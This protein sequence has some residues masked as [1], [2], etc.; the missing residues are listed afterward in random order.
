MPRT[1]E[2]SQVDIDVGHRIRAFR[3]LRGMSQ[4]TL[5]NQLGVTFQQ[6]QKY[7]KGVNR[8][9]AGRLT[10]IAIALGVQP[11]ELLTGSSLSKEALNAVEGSLDA[12]LTVRGAINMLRNYAM[13]PSQDARNALVAS[14]YYM[15]PADKREGL[16]AK[17][18]Y[19]V[20]PSA[21]E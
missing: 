13:V 16:H 14:A 3:L 5:A 9:G 18:V 15:V 8:V 2:P 1:K 21:D 12:F 6:V 4:T 11:G 10:S 17:G 20:S 7:E 19:A